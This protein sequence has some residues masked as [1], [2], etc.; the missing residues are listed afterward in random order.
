MLLTICP[1]CGQ[2]IVLGELNLLLLFERYL[3][4]MFVLSLA[5]R[6]QQYRAYLGFLWAMPDKWPSMYA[7]L[8][9]HLRIFRTWTMLVPVGIAL[10]I[11]AVHFVSQRLIWREAAIDAR[12]LAD[13]AWAIVPVLLFGGAMLYYDL[14]AIFSASR[15][16]FNAIET[17]LQKGEFALTS[18]TVKLVK[19]LTLNRLDVNK[20]VE[21]RVTDTLFGLRLAFMRQLRQQSFHTILRM[22]FGCLL[23]ATW[24]WVVLSL[25][26]LL[27][28]TALGSLIALLVVAWRWTGEGEPAAKSA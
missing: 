9:K 8:K 2:D 20:V 4:L 24:A 22:T 25:S 13:E 26:T 15:V 18:R 7:L 28:V 11:Y 3:L 17:N 5:V 12:Q 27:Y 23:W 10:G 6:Y 16:D 21:S 19:Y 1:V 14:R